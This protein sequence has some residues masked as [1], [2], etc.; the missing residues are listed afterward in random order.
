MLYQGR[1]H[2]LAPKGARFRVEAEPWETARAL[3]NGVEL[4]RETPDR[5]I[6][7]PPG[8][9]VADLVDRLVGAGVKVRAIEPQRQ[10]LEQLYLEQVHKS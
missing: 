3:L 1:W 4:V 9:D 2:E 5:V 6:E 8:A 10:T 7:L